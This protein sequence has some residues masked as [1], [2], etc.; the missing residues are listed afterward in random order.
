MSF[1][2][3]LN[4]EMNVR[5]RTVT[6]DTYGGQ[7]VSLSTIY[8]LRPCR[9]DS[10]GA[11]QQAI[12]NRSGIMASHKVFCDSDMTITAD[13]HELVVGS[14]V[15]RVVSVTDFDAAQAAHH[16]TLLARTPA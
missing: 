11:V 12:L 3:L 1:T 2:G 15:Y 6:V 13:I 8:T 16:L 4:S 14:T 9:V 7:S 5:L 10:L